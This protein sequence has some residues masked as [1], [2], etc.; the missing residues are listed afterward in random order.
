MHSRRSSAAVIIA[1]LLMLA[2]MPHA[3]A[4]SSALDT[5][6]DGLSD[7]D[8]DVNGTS[9]MEAGETDPFNADTDGGG[10]SDGAEV[11][12]KRNPL[13]PNDDM[14]YDAD[15]DGWVNG[16]EAAEKTDPQNADTDGDG[17][18]DSVDAFPNDSK[19]QTD[20]NANH[21]PDDWE[22]IVGLDNSQATPTTADDPD[23]DGLT[24]AEEFARGTNPLLTDSDRDGVDDKTELE[25]S[26]DPME[27]ACLSLSSVTADFSDVHGHWAESFIALLSRTLIAPT[28]MPII[29]GYG[30]TDTPAL[31]HPDLPITRFEF[32]KMVMLSTCAKLRPVS[33][34][35]AITFTDVRADIPRNER[36]EVTL[37]RTVIYSA[38]HYGFIAGY[39]D[40]T[41]RADAPV[42]RAEAL[43]IL[44]LAAGLMKLE[45]TT[46][47]TFS[48]VSPDDWFEPYVSAAASR[49]I[50]SGYG[51]GTFRPENAI[52][53]AE[54][55]KIIYLTMLG[56]PT[57]NGYVLPIE[58]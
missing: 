7:A 55:A 21:L 34:D 4:L 28:S 41:F 48:D 23:G 39:D 35:E 14:T 16:I 25:M 36:P 27:N 6:G 11:A 38:V 5:D 9:T 53:R 13:D 24:N 57:I 54:A 18:K 47:P 56:N 15:G 46:V 43:K 58:E 51:D 2:T 32:L 30:S 26:G 22:A 29:R 45:G 10:E 3:S 20:N 31:F 42:N 52:T 8:E 19:Y 17:V 12:G 40:G 33:D 37:K 44:S 1:L 49:D 50:V